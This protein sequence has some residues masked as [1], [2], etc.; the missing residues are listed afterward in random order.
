MTTS[1]N[2]LLKW[3]DFQENVSKVFS[4][5]RYY[6]DFCDVTLVC[7]GD[8]QFEAHKMVLASSSPV[9]KA[10]LNRN[11]H[12]HPLIFLRGV[13]RE[14]LA[15]IVEYIY[16]GEVSIS[17]E[18]LDKFLTLSED[19]QLK[20]LGKEEQKLKYET[21]NQY[22]TL[23]E[24]ELNSEMSS[25]ENV[26]Q[27][28][29]TIDTSMF[30]IVTSNKGKEIH[31][32]DDSIEEADTNRYIVDENLIDSG[33][34]FMNMDKDELE[35]KIMSIL[36]KE[37]KQKGEQTVGKNGKITKPYKSKYKYICTVCGK[38]SRDRTH[39]WE[40]AETHMEG[41]VYSC[42]LCPVTSK[43]RA[44]IRVHAARHNTVIY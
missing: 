17:H 31:M 19:L 23:G 21:N 37:D 39:G 42:S 13:R 36:R 38:V 16:K 7:D 30:N 20:G 12:P 6:N 34:F 35:A 1:T 40:H 3:S 22:K 44:V 2:Y 24:M 27:N 9:F 26:E 43:S 28:A 11:K 4:E 32:S 14:I 29:K 18:N 10:M 25:H 15:S 5:S 41:L 33:K 8:G